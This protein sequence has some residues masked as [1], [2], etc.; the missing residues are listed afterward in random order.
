MCA[1]FKMRRERPGTG[2]NIEW[3]GLMCQANWHVLSPGQRSH[4]RG[5]PGLRVGV[6]VAGDPELPVRQAWLDLSRHQ[7][8]LLKKQSALNFNYGGAS[9]NYGPSLIKQKGTFG[10]CTFVNTISGVLEPLRSSHGSLGDS[11]TPPGKE[12]LINALS[13]CLFK[14]HSW[15]V[16]ERAP[17]L[18]MLCSGLIRRPQSLPFRET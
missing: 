14:A 10:S 9:G 3:D 15:L 1:L 17:G 16:A 4:W 2:L 6:C 11:N 12:L 13:K 7:P 5:C 8:Q 18:L